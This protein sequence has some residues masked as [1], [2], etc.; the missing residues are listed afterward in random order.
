METTKGQ[1]SFSE[2][3]ATTAQVILFF[4]Q[5]F[6]SFNGTKNQGLRSVISNTSHI[7]YWN[8]AHSKLG[9]MAYVDKT[10]Q[11]PKISAAPC[12]KNW[13][14]T[15]ENCKHLWRMLQSCGFSS[16]DLKHLNQDVLENFFGQIRDNGHR[17]VNPTPFQ[18][19]ASFKI[20][21][22]TNLTSRHSISSNCQK[23]EDDES[24]A[25][26]KMYQLNEKQLNM[27]EEDKVVDCS[28]PVIPEESINIFVDAHNIITLIIKHKSVMNCHQCVDMV[29]HNVT[30]EC[31]KRALDIAKLRFPIFCHNMN[32]KKELKAILMK[33][34]FSSCMFHCSTVTN[35]IADITATRFIVQWCALI[36]AVF[37]GKRQPRE[38]DDFIIKMA[39]NQMYAKSK[40]QNKC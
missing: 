33:E 25:L 16:H 37:N 32:V 5:L 22:T 6:D 35:V 8:E 24:L 26:L 34:I 13:Q 23:N 4:D 31:I 28:A 7:Q 18:F 36:N 12:L 19:Q 38:G 11:P 20:L 9:K 2:S 1:M 14:W 15:I 3:A 40:R 21:L 27:Q 17:N 29:K 10:K 39:Y 30:L